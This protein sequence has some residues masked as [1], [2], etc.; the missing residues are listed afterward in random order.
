NNASFIPGPYAGYSPSIPHGTFMLFQLMF[1]IITPALICGAF[2]ERMKFT[3]MLAFIT[4][5]FLVVY[6]PMAHMVWGENGYFNWA[7]NNNMH[8]AFDFAGG[9]VVHISS[10]IAALM[11]C[12]IMG[13]RKNYLKEIMPPH[14]LTM[15][16]TG[17]CL[18]W[19]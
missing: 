13:K 9:T 16:F 11:C 1:A 14:N 18:L 8:G 12:L 6:L 17:A 3:A 15:S 7:F 10:G 4:G 5:W 19:V 2:A